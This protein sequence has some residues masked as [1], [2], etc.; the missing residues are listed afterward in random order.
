MKESMF[1]KF[2]SATAAIS[3]KSVSSISSLSKKSVNMVAKTMEAGSNVISGEQKK[4]LREAQERQLQINTVLSI[5]D[6]V[7]LQ[8]PVNHSGLVLAYSGANMAPI[9]HPGI[10]FSWFRMSG[11]DSVTQVDESQRSWYAPTAD[12]I[13]CVMCVQC[14]DACSEQGLSKYVECGPIKADS[15]LCSLAETTVDT[16]SYEVSIKE[17]HKK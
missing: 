11:V 6:D 2:S 1:G 10:K 17:A 9:M 5:L 3:S 7:R 12:D 8:C 14:E 4:K 16:G 13:G 15:L